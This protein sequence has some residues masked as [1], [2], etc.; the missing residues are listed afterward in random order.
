MFGENAKESDAR[1][2]VELLCFA[3]SCQCSGSERTERVWHCGK[4]DISSANQ[5]SSGRPR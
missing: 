3:G 4:K 5:I 2:G 1:A